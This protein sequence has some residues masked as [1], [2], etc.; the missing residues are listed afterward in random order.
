MSNPLMEHLWLH[1]E[2]NKSRKEKEPVREAAL[3][4]ALRTHANGH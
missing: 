4:S 2:A 1:A 3:F